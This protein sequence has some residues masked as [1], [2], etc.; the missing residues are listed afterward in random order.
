LAQE[1]YKGQAT[2]TRRTAVNGGI[3]FLRSGG[4]EFL[5]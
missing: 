2:G 4:M 5:R 3:E 1:R